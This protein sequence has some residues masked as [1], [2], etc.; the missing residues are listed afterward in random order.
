MELAVTKTHIKP[1]VQPGWVVDLA[2]GT[3][4]AAV[5][6]GPLH[7]LGYAGLSRGIVEVVHGDGGPGP[8]LPVAADLAVRWSHGA[9]LR[10]VINTTK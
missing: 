9:A 5:A 2:R 6:G 10:E 1:V 7:P 8:G 4:V 3:H